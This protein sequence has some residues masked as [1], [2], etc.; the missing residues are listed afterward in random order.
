VEELDS[1]T[2]QL[3]FPYSYTK[4]CEIAASNGHSGMGMELMGEE[5]DLTP[6]EVKHFENEGIF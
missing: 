2:T 6:Y 1:T 4:S 3:T 5:Y